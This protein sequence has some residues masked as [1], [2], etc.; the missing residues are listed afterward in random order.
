MEILGE[1]AGQIGEVFNS[2]LKRQMM[3]GMVNI[4]STY[5]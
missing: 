1:I 3:I 5:E 2:R 4:N